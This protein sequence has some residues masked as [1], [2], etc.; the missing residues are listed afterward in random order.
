MANSKPCIKDY[1]R[2]YHCPKLYAFEMF[3]KRLKGYD[4]C[5]DCER[6]VDSSFGFKLTDC[7][8][9]FECCLSENLVSCTRC[10]LSSSCDSCEDMYESFN[11][12]GSKCCIRVYKLSKCR[13]MVN[14]AFCK[15]CYNCYNCFGLEGEKNVANLIGFKSKDGKI[16]VQPYTVARFEKFC[17]RKMKQL[18]QD[19]EWFSNYFKDDAVQQ[20]F[21][22]RTEETVTECLEK[23]C[24]VWDMHYK[25]YKRRETKYHVCIDICRGSHLAL[26]DLMQKKE[27]FKLSGTE[28]LKL[29]S[30][31]C[32]QSDTPEE[33]IRTYFKS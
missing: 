15:D 29:S 2:K 25:P 27:A 28:E 24:L 12:K 33:V 22:D 9:A 17:K 7:K 31:K 21:L 30:L 6:V 4:K 18:D 16:D 10:F 14:S 11:S 8:S 13:R 26:N 20:W 5:V 23:F 1:Y 3:I 19:S 32:V